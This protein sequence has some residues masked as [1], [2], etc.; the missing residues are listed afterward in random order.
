MKDERALGRSV[1][2]T[3]V[4][5]SEDSLGKETEVGKDLANQN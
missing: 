2:E 3:E 4:P 5:S 1:V